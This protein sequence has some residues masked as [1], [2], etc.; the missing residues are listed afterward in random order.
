MVMYPRGP[1][2]FYKLKLLQRSFEMLFKWVFKNTIIH[3]L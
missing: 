3:K 2:L 1:K